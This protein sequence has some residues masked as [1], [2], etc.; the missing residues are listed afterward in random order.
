MI[1]QEI[2]KGLEVQSPLFFRSQSRNI[3]AFVEK[4][5]AK[6]GDAVSVICQ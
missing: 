5:I 4:Y 1:D 2:G 3:I 6:S